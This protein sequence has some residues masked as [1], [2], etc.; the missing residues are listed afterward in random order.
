[1]APDG[2]A[3]TNEFIATVDTEDFQGYPDIA[4]L[5]N[6]QFVITWTGIYYPATGGSVAGNFARVF[7]PDGTPATGDISIGSGIFP[8]VSALD[9]GNFVVVWSKQNEIFAK[10]VDASGIEVVPE[11]VVNEI[12]F[13][14]QLTLDISALSGN[15]FIATWSSTDGIDDDSGYGVKARIFDGSGNPLGSEFLVNQNTDANQLEPTVT[16]LSDGGFAIAW[17]TDDGTIDGNRAAIVARIYDSNGEP[18]AVDDGNL[19]FTQADLLALDGDPA[20]DGYTIVSVTGTTDKGSTLTLNPDGSVSYDPSSSTELATYSRN[21]LT[22][23]TLTFLVEDGTGAQSTVS[24]TISVNGTNTAPVATAISR[25]VSEDGAVQT[26]NL[27]A[28]ATDADGDT[29]SVTSI[30][31]VD[32]EGAPVAF[33]NNGDGTISLDPGLFNGLKSGEQR[34]VTV[35]FGL[36]DGTDTTPNKARITIS[37]ANDTPAVVA[38]TAGPVSEDDP[39]ELIDLLAGASDDDGDTLSVVSISAVDDQGTPVAFTDNGDGTISIDPAQYGALGAGESRTVTVSYDVSDG[40]ATTPN[41]A[42]LTVTGAND[43]PDVVAGAAGPVSEDDPVEVIDLLAGASDDDGDT[44]SVVSISAVDDQGTPVSFTD[45]GDGTISIDPAQYNALGA[46]DSRTVTVSYGVSDG[47][48]TTPSTATL[49][50]TGADEINSPPSILPITLDPV[51]EDDPVEVI[52][53]LAGAFDADG[54]SLSAVSISAVDD[55]GTPVA[56]TDNGDGTISI[57]PAQYGALGAGESRTVTV[58]YDVSDGTAAT[59]NTVTLLVTGADEPNTPP[60]I[61]PITLGPVSEQDPIQTI[62]LLDGA[63]DADGDALSAVSVAVTDDLGNVLTVTENGD[64]TVDFDPHQF[65]GLDAGES[66]DVTISYDV[67]D[68]LATTA[69]TVT[70]TV[71]GFDDAPTIAPIVLPDISEDD[72]PLTID[73]LDGAFDPESD[74]L[75]ITSLS[76]TDEF[77]NFVAVTDNGDGTVTLDPAQFGSLNAGESRTVQIQYDLQDGNSSVFNSATI[78]VNGADD[79]ATSGPDV[80]TG[81]PGDDT[82]S[83]FEGDDTITGLAGNDVLNGDEGDDIIDGGDGDDT[84]DG[85]DDNDTISVGGGTNTVIASGGNDTIDLSGAFGVFLDYSG[86]PVPIDI[87][88]SLGAASGSVTKD[89]FGTDT[90][91]G[92]DTLSPNED[93]ISLKTGD[94]SD[95]FAIDVDPD[96][97]I[98][99]DGGLGDDT[100]IVTDGFVRADYGGNGSGITYVS[101]NGPRVS[102]TV[103]G[104]G[105]GT[106]TLGNVAEIRGTEFSDSFTGGAGD[107]R[108]ILRGGSD[109]VDGGG[110][111][112]LVRFDRSGIGAVTVDLALAGP[113][114]TGTIDGVAFSHSLTNI[115]QIRG[116]RNDDDTIA[117][118]SADETF[119]GRGGNDTLLG[120]G[121]SDTLRGEDGDDILDGGDGNDVLEGGAGEDTIDGGEGDDTIDGGDDNDTISVGGGSNTVIASGG[122]D[123][124]DVTGAFGTFFDYTG[125]PVTI[126]IDVNLGPASGTVTKGPYGTDTI[127]GIDTLS[128]DEDGLGFRTGDGNDTFNVNV[129]PDLFIQIDG[130]LGNDT[131]SVTNGSV[132]VSY[133]SNGS[134]ITYVSNDGARV[135][136]TVTGADA[137]TDTLSNVAEIRGTEFDDTFTG[138]AGDERFILRGGNDTVDGGG[139]FDTVRFDRS[140]IG[141]VTVDLAQAGPNA[142]G[143]SNGAAF[144]HS[145]TN[146]EQIRGSRN[147]DDTIAGTSADETFLGRGGNDTLLGRGGSDTLRGEDG[148]DILDGGAGDDTIDGGDG[149]DIAVYSGNRSDYSVTQNGASF[150]ITDLRSGT[151]DGTDDVTNVETFRFADGDVDAADLVQSGGIGPVTDTDAAANGIDE[152]AGA[153][154]LAGITASATD[155]DVS[156]TVSYA[157]DD[158]RFEVDANGVVTVATGASFDAETEGTVDVTVTATSTDG[159]TS[160]E[161]FS[162]TIGDVDE[163]DV[164]P[165]TDSDVAANEIDEDAVAGT[166]VGI[167]ASATDQD[168]SDTVSYAVDDARFGVD[169]NGVVTVAAGAS[170]DAETEGTVDVTVTAT[171]TDG[172]TS[173]ETFTVAIGDVDEFDVGPVTDSDVAA[174]GIDEDAVAGTTVGI[175]ASA[176]DADV[177]DTVSYSVDDARFDIDANGVVTVATGASF[178]AETE[179][180]VDVTVTATSTG[181]STSVETFTVTIGDVDEFD[182]GPVTDS[183]AAANG[184][185]EDAGAGTL[186]GITASATDQDVSDTVGYSVD[187]PR[188][189]VD[190]NGVVTVASGASFDAETEGTVD[191]T[192]TATSTDGSTSVETFTVAI[193]DVDEFDV[194]PVTDSDAAANGID[195]DAVAGTTVGITASATDQDVSDTVGYSV[196]DPRFDVDANG[197]VTVA[198]GASFDAETEGTVDVTVTATST[199]GSTSVE[200]F[201]VAIGDVDEFDVGP[202]TDSDA[203]A[204]EIDE[205]AGAGTLVGITASATDQDVSDTVGYSVDDPRFDVDANGVVTVAAGASFDAETEGTV[206]VT[207]TATSTDGSASNETFTVTIGDVDEFDVGPVTDTDAAANEIDE[208]ASTGTTVGITASATDGDVSDTVSYSVNDARFDIDVNG[209]VTVAAGASFD[210]DSEGTIDLI[211]T[212]TSSDGSFS[213]DTFSIAVNSVA[214]PNSPPQIA[215]L[216][217]GSFLE[218]DGEQVFNLLDGAFD[219]DGDPLTIDLIFATDDVGLVPFI[220][221]G[222]GTI[223]IDLASYNSLKAGE[224]RNVTID[225]EVS[226]GVETVANSAAFVVTGTNDLP[227]ISAVTLA[228]I[229][230]D[231]PVQYFDLFHDAVDPDDDVLSVINISA[232]DE[233][234]SPVTVVDE[235]GGQVSLDPNQFDGLNAGESRTVTIQYDLSDGT[236]QVAN[237]LTVTVQGADEGTPPGGNVFSGTSGDDTHDLVTG[238]NTV[239]VSEGNDTINM[240]AGSQTVFD[241]TAAPVDLT[242]DL[243]AA[244]GSVEKGP[245]AT[246]GTDTI[247]GLDLLDPNTDDIVF[248]LG[249]AN[250]DVTV[251][252]DPDLF[253]QID[254]GDGDDSVAVTNGFVRMDYRDSAAGITYTSN[255]GPRVSGSVTGIDFGTDTLT[256]VAEIRGTEFDDTFNGGDGNERFILRGGSDTVNGGNG[257]DVVRFDRNGIEAVYV[258]LAQAGVN[259]TGTIGGIAFSH[260]LTGIEQIRGSRDGDDIIAGT[261]ADEE[262]RG[263]GGNDELSGREGND[264]LRGG[265][266]ND[267]LNGDEG[268]DTIDGGE[269]D[270]TIDGGDDNDT[271]SVG[272]G[273]N[274]VIASQG[275]DTIDVTGSIDT[276]FDYSG[277]PVPIDFNVTIGTS[278]GTVTKD[279]FGTD[280]ING[281]DSLDVFNDS[282]GFLTGDGNDTF[283]IDID[284][285][286]FVQV[287]GGLGDDTVSVTDGFVRA[288]Y[289]GNGSGITYTSNN[290]SRVSGTVTGVGVGTDTLSNVAEIRGTEFDDTFIGGDGNERFILRGGSDTVDGGAGY[291]VV[292]FDRNGIGPVTVD[293]ALSGS[294][295]TGTSDGV[296]FSHSLTGIEQIRGSREGDDAIAGTAADEEFRGRGGNDTLIGRGGNDTLIGEDGNDILDGG[297]GNDFIEGG[298]GEDTID[299]GDGDDTI[300]GGDDNDTISVGGGSNTVIA[301]GGDDSI[302]VTGA[303]GT[304]F[305]YTGAPVTIDI[306]VNLG[307]A[308]GTVTKGPYGTDTIT[309]I[310]TLSVDEDGLGFRTADGND[311]FNVDVDPDLFIQIDGG[312]GNDTVSVTNG[313]VRVSYLSNG[314]GITYVSNDGARVSGTVTGADAGTDTLVN[315]NEIRGTEFDDTFTGGDGNER[316]ILRGGN[317]TVD[318]GGGFD[319]VRFDRSGIGPVTVDLVAGTATGTSNGIAFSHQLTDIERIRGSRQDD[320]VISGAGADETLEGL[321]GNDILNGRGGN[322]T[323]VGGDGNDTFV[324]AASDGVDT[325]TD[326]EDGPD[327][328][329]LA[330]FGFTSTLD[331]TIDQVGNDTR[332]T[333]LDVGQEIWLTDFNSGQLTD[334]DFKFV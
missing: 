251:N 229:S 179:G 75:S 206:D 141:P 257:Y 154:T 106:D 78:T 243:G 214:P 102:G 194:G 324:F 99:V 170:F 37:G 122:D 188:F 114:A 226:D 185:D 52:D 74:V 121:G 334:D 286:L 33:T 91:T 173:V 72:A 113:N 5:S 320:D 326:F 31:A 272:G 145:L 183:D 247:N 305:D 159:S 125:A 315:V 108:F 166:T 202:V 317:D 332:I 90:I 23:D 68:G 310:D 84:I 96:L 285:D 123:T 155:P 182:V 13:G 55:Q 132:R 97:Y 321:G 314:S 197:V 181:G 189:D 231:D 256:N 311:T 87:D 260:S 312:L 190:A 236:A 27:L 302:D 241:Y 119:L 230:E 148:N 29:L 225:Y 303:F 299:G 63:S 237:T 51:S 150:T 117:G 44:L 228:D 151:P 278:S 306:D 57:D 232:V 135:S 156:D 126:D 10:I 275:N 265:D 140:G 92:I 65:D 192:V 242:I 147:D 218:D 287:K 203:A 144:S 9:S 42:T 295:A 239:E 15:R 82:I 95:D 131:V 290:G 39:V 333:G 252:T 67:S 77:L 222:D 280:T 32:D 89:T 205:D 107:E 253:I 115:E 116:S 284:P 79:G 88:V 30:S 101:N 21:A 111:V 282:L 109:T 127:T 133:L 261:S 41:T 294:N 283:T 100:V 86:A 16:G 216:D 279:T 269:G 327:I 297:E 50:V 184:I 171:S 213:N 153:G 177:S 323:L 196:D 201:T 163:F 263:N 212:A 71:Q 221:N 301:S 103:T 308:S 35:N 4:A 331:F 274:A 207:V 167:T 46:G 325:I 281:I 105:V 25:A 12:T 293:L 136:G 224:T 110:G 178:D 130:G 73:L 93:G 70:F 217:F 47:T 18:V 143:T 250:D 273:F 128:V 208:D 198:S 7:N 43:A 81:T 1:M 254:G 204:N 319:T 233:F 24:V 276:F 164:G 94:G 69:N 129:D 267:I 264:T 38:V 112:D 307:P 169:A 309:G 238:Q 215:P 328:I 219:L 139:G 210:A 234:G 22:S 134:G 195:E 11:F 235:G 19:T 118:T 266:G 98:Q 262:F 137:G 223:S 66:R 180:T 245:G 61:L 26:I 40:T 318:G 174:N 168:V 209:I 277:A 271:I 104:A 20:N 258:D 120:R 161:T 268:D 300:D 49:V 172:S 34:I 292:R 248:L 80:L 288:D 53:L 259:A 6:G 64:G 296:A 3:V 186:V 304:F 200:T 2:S 54:D 48:A 244:T 249:S 124:I 298:E 220:D 316:F 138:G 227:T 255:N 240:V 270:D 162:V 59:P 56:F 8:S 36:S 76:A 187:D 14:S 330:S 142:T 45:N 62:D 158:A 165:V 211:V 149:T 193:G 157:V 58:S 60:T 199:D 176:T 85:G 246:F 28:N 146:I 289:R 160:V 313:S 152:D 83:G 17:R 291:D 175:T 191:V 322:D 329:D